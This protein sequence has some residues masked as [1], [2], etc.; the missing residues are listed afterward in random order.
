MSAQGSHKRRLNNNSYSKSHRELKVYAF[1]FKYP[2][3]KK[4]NNNG[5]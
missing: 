2:D 4:E 3:S 5:Y 1:I